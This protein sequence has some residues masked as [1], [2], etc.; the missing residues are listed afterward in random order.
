MEDARVLRDSACWVGGAYNAGRAVE[1][2]LRGLLMLETR[3]NTSGHDL[4]DLLKQAGRLNLVREPDQTRLLPHIDLL[5]RLWHNN[6]R[7]T[8]C[9]KFRQVIREIGADRR[10]KGDVV[11]YWSKR[12]VR[13]A[14]AVVNRGAQIWIRLSK[15]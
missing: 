8:D 12:M 14:E 9:G 4:R 11:E 10:V 1:A 5:S 3:E 13:S 15:S 7:F 6:L 2:I